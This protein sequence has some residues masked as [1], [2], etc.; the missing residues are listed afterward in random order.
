MAPVIRKSSPAITGKVSI[1]DVEVNT[2]VDTGATT[3]CCGWEWYQKWHSHLGPLC[4]SDKVVIGVG[5]QPV[6]IKGVTR[7]LQ[8]TWD[9]V[10]AS[11]EFIVLPTLKEVDV[12]L[13]MD[14]LKELG[15]VIQAGSGEARPRQQPL[16]SVL[17]VTTNKIR[18]PAGKA[19]VFFVRNELEGLTLFEPSSSLPEGLQGVPTLSHGERVAVQL[20]NHSDSDILLNPEW[21]IGQVSTVQLVVKPPPTEPKQVPEVPESLSKDQQK[22]LKELL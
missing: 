11:C 1:E 18:I 2:L 22:Q 6:S 5:N 9:T 16:G 13:G 21:N 19:K 14:I 15:V 10:K 3:S 7:P 12:L 4:K 8:V 20:D 17:L